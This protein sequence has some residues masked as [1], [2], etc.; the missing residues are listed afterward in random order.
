MAR[1]PR[2][3][4]PHIPQ[5]IVQRGNNRQVSFFVEQDYVVYLDKLKEYARKYQVDIHA[6]VLMTNHV[7]LLVSPHTEKGVSQLMQSL[8]RYYVRYINQTHKRSGTLW[9]GRY[10]STLVDCEQYLLLVSRY[11]ELNPVRADM[12][13]HPAEYPWSSYHANALDKEIELV[14]PHPIYLKLGQTEQQR[15]SRYQKLFR[16]HIPEYSL[17]EIRD[18]TNK[19]WVLGNERFQQQIEAQTGRR[20]A[21]M[22]RGGDRKSKEYREGI[23]SQ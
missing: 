10:K 9:E 2:L 22:Q 15:K 4:L 21:P 17:K 11:I 20:A 18:A 12:V 13:A 5:H 16:N 3:N 19:A 7:H 14:I 8:G 23:E 1:L 6:F